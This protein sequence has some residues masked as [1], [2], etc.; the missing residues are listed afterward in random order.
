MHAATQTML[1]SIGLLVLRLGMGG[2]MLTHGWPK[3]QMVING[4]FDSFGDPIGLGS[5]MSLLLIT[6]AEF[7][8][9]LL[10]VLGLFTRFAAI[11]LV[12]GM[13]VAAF[14]AHSSD[15]WTMGEGAR[16][17]QAGEAD[18]WSSKEPALMY[19]SAFLTLAFTGPGLFSLD[20]LIWPKLAKSRRA[21]STAAVGA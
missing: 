9:A 10:V 14:F 16:L 8:C 15:P 20:R 21:E 19:L 18:A 17:F 11:P 4:N 7:F 2:Y 6:F 12:I 13:G 3:L 1:T 5:T